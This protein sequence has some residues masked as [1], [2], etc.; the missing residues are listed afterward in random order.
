MTQKAGQKCTAIRRVYVPRRGA[1]WRG[2][3]A[4]RSAGRGA[5]RRSRAGG[6]RHGT[7]RRPRSSCARRGKASPSWSGRAATAFGNN[8]PVDAIGAG[9]KGF[10]L[11][12]VLLVSRSPAPGDAVHR[13]E[14][15]GPVATVIAYDGSA[16]RAADLVGWGGGGLVASV[17][18]DDRAFLEDAVLG[19][20]PYHGRVTIGSSKIAGQAIPPGTVLPQLVHG[21]PGRAGPGEELGGRRGMALYL[22]RTAIQGDRALVVEPSPASADRRAR[23][24][25]SAPGGEGGVNKTL[26]AVSSRAHTSPE[27]FRYRQVFDAP[28]GSGGLRDARGTR[29]RP[30]PEGDGPN[31]L[32]SWRNHSQEAAGPGFAR[33]RMEGSADGSHPR[34][35]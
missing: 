24:G 7:P 30:P 35:R 5:G 8:G 17:Y 31:L 27:K 6:G 4:P 14:V 26:G 10:F 2:G 33:C 19:L 29:T 34:H 12:P 13:R 16:A 1:R 3:G 9:G 21:G 22:Q 28:A 23:G 11:G 32:D 25:F 15:F 18:S 20:A